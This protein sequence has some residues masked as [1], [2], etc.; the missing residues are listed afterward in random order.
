MALPH[1]TLPSTSTSSL[2]PRAHHVRASD[3]GELALSPCS[4]PATQSTALPRLFLCR[5]SPFCLDIMV[6]FSLFPGIL[7]VDSLVVPR[8][9]WTLRAVDY[10]CRLIRIHHK[11]F[12]TIIR[13]YQWIGKGKT[14]EKMEMVCGKKERKEGRS[15]KV[16]SREFLYKNSAWVL[17]TALYA[18]YI[19]SY[20]FFICQQLL[21]K[22][23][24][25]QAH[26]I[27]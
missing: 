26:F 23:L 13:I 27:L 5:S 9:I 10:F 11:D 4:A 3:C 24:S 21:R 14:K 25:S 17:S 1:N 15:L 6:S 7:S 16:A 20:L 22:L 2:L 8:K 18:I 19:S 12:G